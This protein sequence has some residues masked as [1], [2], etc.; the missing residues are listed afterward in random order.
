MAQYEFD[1]S[2]YGRCTMICDASHCPETGAAGFAGWIAGTG[3]SGAVDG[4]VKDVVK[5]SNDAEFI[6]VINC[7]H[8]G[9]Q[10]GLIRDG[11][12][13]LIQCDNENV[14]NALTGRKNATTEVGIKAVRL[15]ADYKH[16]FN[17]SFSIRW[18]KGHA[19]N[20]CNKNRAHNKCDETAKRH[21]KRRRSQLRANDC[22]NMHG[23]GRNKAPE[24]VDSSFKKRTH[25]AMDGVRALQGFFN[26]ALMQTGGW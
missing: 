20:D 8:M 10:R 19:Q 1:A 24:K 9:L 13:V 17:L 16:R 11:Y 14:V 25:T 6:A 4:G 3:G 5:S 23:I 21:M 12:S 18:I 2:S 15:F 26:G 7:L 22:R